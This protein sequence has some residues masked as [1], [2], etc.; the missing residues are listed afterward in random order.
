LFAAGVQ[1]TL[2]VVSWA[3][4]RAMFPI[5]SLFT[6]SGGATYTVRE[7][8]IT[9]WNQIEQSGAESSAVYKWVWWGYARLCVNLAHKKSF[10]EVCVVTVVV[11][12]DVHVDNV[13]FLKRAVVWNAVTDDLVDRRAARFGKLH[14]VEWG[15][16]AL[17]L[18]RGIVTHAVD[19]SAR[20]TRC[21][22]PPTRVKNLA[23]VWPLGRWVRV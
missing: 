15:W 20:H 7:A 1:F 9:E 4:Q 6:N 8:S 13:A 5:T 22:C 14:V 11:D 18:N 10:V 12:R 16:V 23:M 3:R 19:L 21:D 2:G 17:A